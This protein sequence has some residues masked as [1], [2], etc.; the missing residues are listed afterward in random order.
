MKTL[1]TGNTADNT[2]VSR[3]ARRG[4]LIKVR[5]LLISCLALVWAI[6]FTGQV[7]AAELD[8]LVKPEMYV[9]VSSPVISVME[10]ILVETKDIGL[11]QVWKLEQRKINWTKDFILIFVE[12][13]IFTNG[14]PFINEP[15]FGSVSKT[16][17]NGM[18]GENNYVHFGIKIW[19]L[20][21][22]VV[23]TI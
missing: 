22:N 3:Q 11:E 21:K 1:Q 23:S 16:A 15:S 12:F 8:C 14:P 2:S 7:S 5:A 18:E 17:E 10:E 4:Y 20:M 19:V 6:F 13:S 9:E